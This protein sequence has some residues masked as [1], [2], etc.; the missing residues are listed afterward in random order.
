MSRVTRN[1]KCLDTTLGQVFTMYH[2]TRVSPKPLTALNLLTVN[3]PEAALSRPIHEIHDRRSILL[4]NRQ[5]GD[6]HP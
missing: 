5:K 2:R 1:C 4:V 3:L 6:F